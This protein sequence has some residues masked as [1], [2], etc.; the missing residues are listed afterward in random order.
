MSNETYNLD[1]KCTN[2]G[3]EQT[4]TI[5]K[6]HIF[7]D[8]FVGWKRSSHTNTGDHCYEKTIVCNNCRCATITRRSK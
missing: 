5:T 6:G 7:H 1:L 8:C 4:E 3:H 2:C